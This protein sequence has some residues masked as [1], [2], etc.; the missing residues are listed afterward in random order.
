MLVF[1]FEPPR[2]ELASM[3]AASDAITPNLAAN[4]VIKE[5]DYVIVEK[6]YEPRML[7]ARA[8]KTG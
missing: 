7:V 4:N 2:D 3:D 8:A 6:I 1:V 5:G